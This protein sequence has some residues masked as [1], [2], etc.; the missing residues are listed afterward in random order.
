MDYIIIFTF[1][2]SCFV[3]GTVIGLSMQF[4]EILK[5]IKISNTIDDLNL[6]KQNLISDIDY[7]EKD[8]NKLEISYFSKLEEYNT[9]CY[10]VNELK[11]SNKKVFKKK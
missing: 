5:K 8:I 7:L 11:K 3:L 2:I 1:L 4:N 6:K 9:L 10:F